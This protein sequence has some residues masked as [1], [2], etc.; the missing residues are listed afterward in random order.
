MYK[1]ASATRGDR[2]LIDNTGPWLTVTPWPNAWWNLN[3]QLT[4]WPLNTSNH[5][6]LARSLE[7][8]IYGNIEN[9]RTNIPEPYRYN[10][11]GIG[12]T[13]DLECASETVKNPR[14]DPTA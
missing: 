9:L 2:A 8:A 14:K 3:V 1:L 7:N 10:S 6:D 4:Y 13:S 11:L 5:L 12:R